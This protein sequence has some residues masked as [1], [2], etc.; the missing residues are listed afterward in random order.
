MDGS[1]VTKDERSV[2][3]LWPATSPLTFAANQNPTGLCGK[4]GSSVKWILNIH[5]TKADND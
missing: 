4:N 2:Y 3:K 1:P 5:L